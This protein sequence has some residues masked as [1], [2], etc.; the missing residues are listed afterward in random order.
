ML[1]HYEANEVSEGNR[2]EAEGVAHPTW[3]WVF[4][5]QILAHAQDAHFFAG[6][7]YRLLIH[8]S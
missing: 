5:V 2:A 3:G 1:E 8:F 6:K 7:K 4:P